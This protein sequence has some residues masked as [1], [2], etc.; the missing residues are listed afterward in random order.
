MDTKLSYL[1]CGSKLVEL[2]LPEKMSTNPESGYPVPY[3]LKV[4]MTDNTVMFLSLK[5]DGKH[6]T[7]SL[8]RELVAPQILEVIEDGATKYLSEHGH[9]A[10]DETSKVLMGTG[11]FSVASLAQRGSL[12]GTFQVKV[13]QP[14]VELPP[15]TQ[16]SASL[17]PFR[18]GWIEV[19]DADAA[20]IEARTWR[21]WSQRWW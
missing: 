21:H 18:I 3:L 15:V 2:E 20:D 13:R 4:I 11:Q 14:G 7:C 9:P 16:A 17:Q 5:T 8:I 6:R 10:Y 12:R 1:L 19:I